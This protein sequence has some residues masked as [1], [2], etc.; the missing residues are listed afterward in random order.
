MLF[1]FKKISRKTGHPFDVIWENESQPEWT[2]I[3]SV[4]FFSLIFLFVG[5]ALAGTVWVKDKF[6]IMRFNFNY[7][8]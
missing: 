4:K 2:K 1:N 3:Q 6:E 5:C 8:S 7:E